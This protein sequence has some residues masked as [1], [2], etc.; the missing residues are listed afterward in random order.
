M[1]TAAALA[2]AGVAAVAAQTVTGHPPTTVVD[3]Q[4]FL[5]AHLPPPAA[6]PHR[7]AKPSK[8]VA[9]LLARMTL[10]E[11]VGQMTQLTVAMVASGRDA[12]LHMDPV[13]LQHAVG[14]YGVG[15]I[16][17][18]SDQALP[19]ERW[20]EVLR[21]IQAAAAKTRLGIPVLYG[22]DTIHGANYVRGATL[23]PQPLGMAA[24][25]NPEL[26]L[27]GSRI[28]AHE[29][30]A[31]GIP[32]NFSPVL[33]VGR[34]PLWPRLYETFGEDS[35]LGSVMGVATVRGYQGDDIPHGLAT[36]RTV[37]ATLKHYIGYS[38]PTTGHDRTP[39]LIPELVLREHF[40]PPFAAAVRAGAAAVM[41]NS[42]EVNGTPGH[43]NG[44]LLKDV[45]RGELGFDGLVVSDW[46][47]IK[48]LVTIH[49]V[50]ADEKEATRIAVLAGIDMSMVPLDYSF[51]DILVSL[52]E[53]GA[54]PMARI[55]EA[56]GRVLTLKEKLGL[57]DDPLLGTASGAEVRGAEA[58][59]VALEAARESIV[60]LANGKG[61]LPLREAA[62]VLVTGPTCDSRMALNNGWSLTWQG[63]QEGLYA[64]DRPTIRGAIAAKLGPG[65]VTYVP[66]ATYDAEVDVAA[67]AAA[68]READVAIVCLGEMAY[69]ETPGNIDDL[70]LPEAQLRL[71]QAVAASGKPM[72]L[73]LVEGRPRL[74]RPIV[75]LAAAIVLA[76][77]PGE[78]GGQAIADVLFG[79]VNPSGKLPIT[80]PRDPH[81]LRTYDHK[82]FEEQD[83]GFGLTAFRPQFEFG[84]GLS[85]TTF[86]YSALAVTPKSV[87]PSGGVTVAV[88]VRNAGAR[89]GAEVV[90]LYVSDL[91]ASVTPPVKRLRRFAKVWLEP[92]ESR[93]LTFTLERDDLSFI[94]ADD[95]RTVEPGDFAVSVGGLRDTFTLAA[96]S[97]NKGH[98]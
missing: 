49:R 13:K 9:G 51:A 74:M 67:A 1:R 58:Q 97:G 61:M 93:Q 80:Y 54:V 30:R 73:V 43:A 7:P 33:D 86:E 84:S 35:Y 63:N 53:E 28:A 62:H 94:G 85:Y 16:L 59:A 12:D 55:D 20:H 79:D 90:Q 77:N 48:K 65:G 82:A 5:T 15:S 78:E 23:F 83:T 52:V 47:D 66:G 22:I 26:M 89:A 6:G 96:A 32:W 64:T 44:F 2:L 45:L 88:T 75:D 8:R 14:D 37:A 81:A 95:K 71:A 19:L 50:A 68:A 76:L 57:F 39:A 11:K 21:D 56:A 10:R 27:A 3:S 38:F 4:A 87:A 36:P 46:E 17:N 60:L 24:T 31:A 69:A 40:L 91:V 18:V 98:E 29:T 34:Q 70:A 42:G 41:V 72:V 92:G 25:W